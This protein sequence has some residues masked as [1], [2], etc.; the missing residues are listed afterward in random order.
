MFSYRFAHPETGAPLEVIA[1]YH[2]PQRGLR[3]CHGAPE[4]PDDEEELLVCDVWDA[5]G[6]PVEFDAFETALIE[7]GLR[8]V[9]GNL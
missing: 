8:T 2:P 7:A 5:R 1:A 3:D 9:R 4:E 6:E